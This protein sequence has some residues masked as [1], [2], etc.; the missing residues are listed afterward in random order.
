MEVVYGVASE[1]GGIVAYSPLDP[2]PNNTRYEWRARARDE[3]DADGPWSARAAFAVA[4]G[5]TAPTTPS[6]LSPV[7]RL[8]RPGSGIV[9]EV[10]N[11]IDTERDA[12]TYQF[13]VYDDEARGSERLSEGGVLPGTDGV[14]RLIVDA[15]LPKACTSG[16]DRI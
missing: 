3:R 10:Q 7:A 4:A 2:L 14:T 5:N 12:L 1:G 11:S 6:P 13:V 8:C 9:F 16:S 15:G